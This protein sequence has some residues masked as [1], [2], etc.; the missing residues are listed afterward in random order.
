MYDDDRRVVYVEKRGNGG[1]KTI[2]IVILLG[3]VAWG[4][5]ST[6]GAVVTF[7]ALPG[8][9]DDSMTRMAATPTGYS[10]PVPAATPE[11]QQQQQPDYEATI[12][13]IQA[14][15]AATSAPT[16]TPQPLIQDYGLPNIGPYS[17]DQV[18]QCQDIKAS[19]GLQVLP[20]PQFELCQQYTR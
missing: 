3:I 17:L 13:A 8:A 10:Q 5:V 15:P 1:L 6:R 4:Y 16:Q 11:Q 14:Q 12:E 2:L 19:S 7:N 9:I 20:S 18:R